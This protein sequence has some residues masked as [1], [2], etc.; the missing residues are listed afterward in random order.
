M[1]WWAAVGKDHSLALFH[2]G[3]SVLWERLVVVKKRVRG[4]LEDFCVRMNNLRMNRQLWKRK[5]QK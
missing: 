1:E 4:A 2:F 5:K 3:E